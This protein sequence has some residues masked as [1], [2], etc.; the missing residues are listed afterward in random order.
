VL[1]CS[2][3][4]ETLPA[5]SITAEVNQ[6]IASG[7]LRLPSAPDKEIPAKVHGCFD[8]VAAR[9]IRGGRGRCAC[10][11]EATKAERFQT[12]PLTD[13]TTWAEAAAML[14]KVPLLDAATLRDDSHT[15]VGTDVQSSLHR[16]QSSG[17][18][19]QSS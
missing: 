10:H 12:P 14:Q 15:P 9:G 11:A 18:R 17:Q 8:L 3:E 2:G 5:N 19:G 13:A 1:L 4:G 6:V 16:G 7:R